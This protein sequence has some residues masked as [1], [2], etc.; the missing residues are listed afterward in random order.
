MD[1][2]GVLD[3]RQHGLPCLLTPR[4]NARLTHAHPNPIPNTPNSQALKPKAQFFY[5]MSMS[6]RKLPR[7]F[8]NYFLVFFPLNNT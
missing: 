2:R 4:T 8:S 3:R 1:R 6:G 5:E 7:W